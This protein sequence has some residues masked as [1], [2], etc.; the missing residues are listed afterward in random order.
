MAGK[1]VAASFRCGCWLW[2]CCVAVVLCGPTGVPAPRCLFVWAGLP[3]GPGCLMC[4]WAAARPH[5]NFACNS[6]AACSN[7]EFASSELQRFRAVSK[8]NR[9]KLCA[10]FVWRWSCR[11]SWAPLPA[12]GTA[13]KPRRHPPAPQP[14]PAATHRHC[15]QAPPPP[16]GTAAKPLCRPAISHVIPQQLVQILNLHRWN[17]NVSGRSRKVTVGNYVRNLSGRWPRQHVLALPTG[18]SPHPG[19][20]PLSTGAAAWPPRFLRRLPH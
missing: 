1:P 2:W 17:C 8:S 12:T 7:I 9:G 4:P 11:H 18:R 10:K 14:S 15:S 5:S 16:T 19:R 13:A 3:V 20:V 6:P